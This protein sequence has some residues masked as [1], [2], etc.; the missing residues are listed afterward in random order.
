[1]QI[2]RPRVIFD[3]HAI[4]IHF[5]PVYPGDAAVLLENVIVKSFKIIFVLACLT[6][7][8]G[9]SQ[10]FDDDDINNNEPQTPLRTPR[11]ERDPDEPRSCKGPDKKKGRVALP[12]PYGGRYEP[13]VALNQQVENAINEPDPEVVPLIPRPI[14]EDIEA[15]VG[16]PVLTDEA[17]EEA[18][19]GDLEAI[20]A[21]LLAEVFENLARRLPTGCGWES[22]EMGH[23]YF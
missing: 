18:Y 21:R 16:V 14:A 8:S 5:L 23:R 2:D 6:S 11:R 15:M 1:M 9:L 10:P 7:F 13:T 20:R 19:Q 4:D 3:Q 12:R 17:R 22:G